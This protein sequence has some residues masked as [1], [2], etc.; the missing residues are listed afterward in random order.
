[1]SQS[2]KGSALE[3][4]VSIA[5]GLVVSVIANH[6]VFPM[7]GFIP[8]FRQNAEITVIYTAISFVR[9]YG[10]RR[11]FNYFGQLKWQRY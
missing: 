1:M 7:Y 4:I 11:L 3:I 6:F 5:I 10:V 8:S 9:G 2:R